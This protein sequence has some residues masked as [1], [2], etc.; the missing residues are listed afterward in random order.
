MVPVTKIRYGFVQST[1][2]GPLLV[3]VHN[4]HAEIRC[5]LQVWMEYNLSSLYNVTWCNTKNS[6]Y[7]WSKMPHTPNVKL[8]GYW[9]GHKHFG[10]QKMTN[11]RNVKQ[12]ILHFNILPFHNSCCRIS[13][14]SEIKDDFHFVFIYT[15][16]VAW[17]NHKV[18]IHFNLS[19][20][21]SAI[22]VLCFYIYYKI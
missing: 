7:L 1:V 8:H 6:W 5:C 2:P 3:I 16:A 10:I 14:A 18:A 20:S 15:G 19:A 22:K 12:F 13:D 11:I 9:R 4:P 21:M 17:R